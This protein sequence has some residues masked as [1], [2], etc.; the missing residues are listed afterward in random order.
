VFTGIDRAKFR[1]QVIP[2]DQLRI[3]VLVERFRASSQHAA[4]RMKG[5][6]YVG[7]Q[8]AAEA[9]ISCHLVDLDSGQD[10]E[11]AE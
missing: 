10:T 7:D 1:R 3:E 5:Y 4:G 9:T 8:L 6:A 11:R 2:G